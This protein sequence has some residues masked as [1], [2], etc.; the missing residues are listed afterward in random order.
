MR[1]EAGP[2]PVGFLHWITL[3]EGEFANPEALHMRLVATAAS[4]VE[5]FPTNMWCLTLGSIWQAARR[6]GLADAWLYTVSTDFLA[7]DP[8]G[9]VAGMSA[10]PTVE[11]AKIALLIRVSRVL[12]NYRI[13]V[14]YPSTMRFRNFEVLT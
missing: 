8:H 14:R 11:E 10:V 7:Y 12:R 3:G 1:I 4:V 13:P 9:G 5:G 6:R 2:A